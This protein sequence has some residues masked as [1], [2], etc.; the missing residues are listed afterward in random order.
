MQ[1]MIE[2]LNHENAKEI[3]DN[4]K[5]PDR[6]SFYNMTEDPDDYE[7]ITNPELRADN[8]FQVLN[9][10]EL[11]GFFAL[12]PSEDVIEMGI[13]IKPEYTG[14]GLG[15]EFLGLIIEFIKKNYNISIIRLSVVD[16]N[17]RAQKVYSRLGFSKT[18]EY[19]QETNNS[20]YTFIEMERQL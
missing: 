20:V 8:Y 5:Y 19:S 1:F 18:K 15:E 9:N 10:D 11:F 4:W 6:Y 7:E 2:K 14:R 17:V 13:G 16:F 12:Y 3:A